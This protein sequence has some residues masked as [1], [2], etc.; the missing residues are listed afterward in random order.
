MIVVVDTNVWISA[1]HF[2][3]TEGIPFRALA[4]A[5]AEDTMGTCEEIETEIFNTLKFTCDWQEARIYAVM[6]GTLRR[7]IRV[8]ITGT[9]RVCR[10]PDD[11][12]FL[13]CAERADADL[14]ISGDKDLLAL[15]RH[16][17]TRIVTPAA[18]LK[19]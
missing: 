2:G 8:N 16:G 13:E 19:G 15:R 7:A 12:K 4:R 10:D 1:L 6:E 18:C 5:A 17:R 3:G 9:L 11:D 14:L